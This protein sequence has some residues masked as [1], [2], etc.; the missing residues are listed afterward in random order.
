MT[1]PAP[2]AVRST[3]DMWFGGVERWDLIEA[4]GGE[5][6]GRIHLRWRRTEHNDAGINRIGIQ[7]SHA[8]AGDNVEDFRR[9]PLQPVPLAR[10]GVSVA[11]VQSSID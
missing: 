11:R 7:G 9:V 2:V 1:P 4:V 8:F 5:V 6:G 3:F 10:R